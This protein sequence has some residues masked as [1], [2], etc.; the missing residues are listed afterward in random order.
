VTRLAVIA[1]LHGLLPDAASIPQ[2]DALL[3][4]GDIIP[5]GASGQH[6]M[7]DEQSAW[8]RDQLSPWVSALA[9]R[10]PVVAVCGNGDALGTFPWGERELRRLAWTY[11]RDQTIELPG[12]LRVHGS[13]WSIHDPSRPNPAGAFQQSEQQLAMRWKRLRCDFDVLLSHTPP[14]DRLDHVGERRLGSP[15]LATWLARQSELGRA[16][17]V[18]CGHVHEH[19]GFDGA[20][21]NA[22]ISTAYPGR[23][24][25]RM[26]VLDDAGG[27]WSATWH[28]IPGR[29]RRAPLLCTQAEFTRRI[30]EDQASF[31]R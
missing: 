1:D 14:H 29:G 10:M 11:L 8:V 3:I 15:S 4:A 6:S 31:A 18:V 20:V 27:A 5:R 25:G 24:R 26:L 2:V 12:G 7:L 22:S 13:P 28:P 30:A 21:A 16:P 19:P 23:Q 9:A 17:L